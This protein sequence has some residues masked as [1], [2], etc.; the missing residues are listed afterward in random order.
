MTYKRKCENWLTT[1]MDWTTPKSITPDTVL[2]WCGLFAMSASLRRKVKISREYLGGWECYPS[3]YIMFVAP[4]GVITKSTSIARVEEMFAELPTNTVIEGTGSMTVPV[5]IKELEESPDSSL[6]L[7]ISEWGTFIKK[8][9]YDMYDYLTDLF[10]NKLK[11]NEKTFIR[12]MVAVDKPVVNLLAATTPDWVKENMTEAVMGGGFS[13]RVVAIHED[14]AKEYR[15]FYKGLIDFT[16]LDKLKADLVSDLVHIATEIEGE[17][18]I[19]KEAMELGEDWAKSGVEVSHSSKKMKGW[20]Q[21]RAA[22]ML[23]I[24]MLV[25]LSSSDE[26]VIDENVMQLAMNII[27]NVEPKIE[28]SYRSVGKNIY[29]NIIDD[30]EKF[31]IAKK[32]VAPSELFNRF[33][34][35]LEARKL[36][37]VIAAL[38]QMNKIKLE[39]IGKDYF[40]APMG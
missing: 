9:G 22:Y 33:S 12:G 31:I 24:A 23:K 18:E 40:Y 25:K 34:A 28:A 4:P 16:H 30:V 27:E 8:A 37:E 20:Q 35:E 2:F 14:K 7:N 19:S 38:M 17:F 10:D 39:F 29:I 5:L 26:L 13:S 3:L 32:M 11:F 21:R 15:L 1:W 6:Y 36:E